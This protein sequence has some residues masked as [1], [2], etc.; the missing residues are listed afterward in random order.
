LQNDAIINV[1]FVLSQILDENK[2]LEVLK[3][4]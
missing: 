2:N 4:L 3:T 1:A